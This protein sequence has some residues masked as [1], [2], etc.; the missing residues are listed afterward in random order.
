MTID[1]WQT[2]PVIK[3]YTNVK[4]V[5][6]YSNGNIKIV[7]EYDG[8]IDEHHYEANSYRWYSVGDK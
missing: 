7:F 5:I 3:R 8:K 4:Q 6:H 2:G 1:I